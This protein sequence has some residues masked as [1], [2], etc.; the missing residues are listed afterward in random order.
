MACCIGAVA[1]SEPKSE[2]RA[3]PHAAKPAPKATKPGSGQLAWP[4]VESVDQAVLRALPAETQAAIAKT[5][6]PVLWP[7][8]QLSDVTFVGERAFY[9]VSGHVDDT[10]ASGERSRAT[11]QV[12]AA[13]ELVTHAEFPAFQP[14]ARVRGLGALFTINEDIATV[15]W[16]EHGVSYAVDVECSNAKDTRCQGDAFVRSVADSLSFVGG[17][18]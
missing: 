7:Q 5:P 4:K 17:A 2:V 18:R 10:L 12:H 15:T 8:T 11:I 14:N 1:C 13:R 3:E 6:L 9:S 16:L